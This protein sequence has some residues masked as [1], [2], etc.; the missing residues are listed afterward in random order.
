MIRCS[1][2]YTNILFSCYCR[3]GQGSLGVVARH[4]EVQS[5]VRN[6]VKPGVT[7]AVARKHVGCQ[8]RTNIAV[9]KCQR[10][11]SRKGFCEICKVH[12]NDMQQVC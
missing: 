11:T 1:S 8:R 10:V 5:V 6:A 12:F 2:Y 7:Y 9:T 4:G 3:R